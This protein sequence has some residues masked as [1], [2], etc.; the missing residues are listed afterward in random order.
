MN[1]QL[2]LQFVPVASTPAL[3]LGGA[4]ALTQWTP[5]GI[6]LGLLNVTEPPGETVTLLGFQA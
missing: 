6:E 3:Q 2:P 1:A 4:G 5:C